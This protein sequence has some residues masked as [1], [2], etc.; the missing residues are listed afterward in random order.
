MRASSTHIAVLLPGAL[1]GLV[2]DLAVEHGG[3]ARVDLG[4]LRLLLERLQRAG[5]CGET[6]Q[7]SEPGQRQIRDRSRVRQRSETGQPQ[8]RHRSEVRDRSRVRQRSVTGRTQV[9]HRSGTG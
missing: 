9:R 6:G 5:S 8:V 3:L 2:V 7:R 4:V 1:P